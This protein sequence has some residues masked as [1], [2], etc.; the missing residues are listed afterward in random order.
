[1]NNEIFD[2]LVNSN[3][4][5]AEQICTFIKNT[6][7]KK[8]KV[9]N[10][11]RLMILVNTAL[12]YKMLGDKNSCQRILDEEDWSA[13]EDLFKFAYLI[14]C[15]NREEAANLMNKVITKR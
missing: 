9:P 5:L 10:D 3:F 13:V 11:I 8:I 4:I 15:E 12:T 7:N 14:L 2:L 1:L 6:F